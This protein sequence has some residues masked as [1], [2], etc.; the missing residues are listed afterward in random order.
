MS[1]CWLCGCEAPAGVCLGPHADYQLRG[2][3][4]GTSLYVELPGWW[5]RSVEEEESCAGDGVTASGRG[6]SIHYDPRVAEAAR[7]R[8]EREAAA[9]ARAELERAEELALLYRLAAKHGLVVR[10]VVVAGAPAARVVRSADVAELA[11]AAG[12]KPVAHAWGF[13][14]LRQHQSLT[15]AGEGR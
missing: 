13:E 11:D 3:M 1:R 10:R 6:W 9:A 5:P 8:S 14:S 15:A 2:P 12:S 4:G 7:L